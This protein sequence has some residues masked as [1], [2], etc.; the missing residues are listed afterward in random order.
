[1]KVHVLRDSPEHLEAK[2]LELSHAMDA[3]P[4]ACSGPTCGADRE[5]ESPDNLQP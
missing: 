1:M 5:K 3:L 4:L 2:I